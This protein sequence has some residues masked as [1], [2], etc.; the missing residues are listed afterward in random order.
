MGSLSNST[1]FESKQGTFYY[2]LIT[3]EKKGPN[4]TKIK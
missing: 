3:L 4:N 2:N 1:K